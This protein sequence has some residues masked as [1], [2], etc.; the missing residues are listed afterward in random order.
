LLLL[1]IKIPEIDGFRMYEE[2]KEMDDKVR[3][4]YLT[5]SDSY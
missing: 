2:L 3:V 1:D 4:C 5:V